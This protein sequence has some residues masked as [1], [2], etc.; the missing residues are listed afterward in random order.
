MDLLCGRSRASHFVHACWRVVC[1]STQ[2]IVCLSTWPTVDG[3]NRRSCGLPDFVKVRIQRAGWH[4]VAMTTKLCPALG[5]GTG[6]S[7]AARRG[8][9]LERIVHSVAV[10]SAR[11]S[12]IVHC[13][14]A[15]GAKS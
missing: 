12:T 1:L 15:Q 8:T 10:Q 13:T 11:S 2:P 3:E 4:A 7:T 5:Q 6:V 14:I 9:V